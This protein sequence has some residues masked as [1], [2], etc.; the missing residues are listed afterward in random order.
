MQ[1]ATVLNRAG[2]LADG[3]RPNS[4][5]AGLLGLVFFETSLRTRVGFAAAAHRMGWSSV[6]VLQ[7]RSSE[8]SMPESWQDTLRTVGAYTD[9]VIGRLGVSLDPG[10]ISATCPVPFVNGGSRG[11]AAEH[12]TQALIDLFA[13]QRLSGPVTSSRIAVCGD[14]GMRSVRSLF[15]LLAMGA[16]AELVLVSAPTEPAAELPAGLVARTSSLAELDVDV[17]YVAGMGHGWHEGT[18]RDQLRVTPRVLESLP[19]SAIVLSPMPLIDEMSDEARDQ[20]V[21]VHDQSALGLFVRMAVL[22]AVSGG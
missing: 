12:P 5:S 2:E 20:K 15:A 8:I 6:E 22:E 11:P 13:I 1:L 16:P 18:G 3:A 17:L 19:P 21:R 4:A 14:L 7:P 9:L 10:E